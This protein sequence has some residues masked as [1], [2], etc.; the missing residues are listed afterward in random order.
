VRDPNRV[1]RGMIISAYLLCLMHT[2]STSYADNGELP[3]LTPFASPDVSPEDA[4]ILQKLE[5]KVA[6]HQALARADLGIKWV[7]RYLTSV[8]SRPVQAKLL[9]ILA[10]F[11]NEKGEVREAEATL[12]RALTEYGNTDYGLLAGD[13]LIDLFS[14]TADDKAM[15][16]AG[17]ILRDKTLTP[18]QEIHFTMR[19]AKLLAAN[20]NSK[21]ALGLTKHLNKKYPNEWQAVAQATEAVAVTIMSVG[22]EPN[23]TVFQNTPIAVAFSATLLMLV[24]QADTKR[25]H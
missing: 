13:K 7:P 25:R 3:P 6:N 16:L 10:N 1:Y 23:R 9:V 12:R 18:L 2:E 17:G 19:L 5:L 15:D 4:E 11:L 14:G 20:G 24:N 8:K 21:E 22:Q